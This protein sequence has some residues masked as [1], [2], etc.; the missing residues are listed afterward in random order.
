M[1]ANSSYAVPNLQVTPQLLLRPVVQADYPFLQA[2][3]REVRRDELS[4]T[5]WPQAAKDAFCDSQFSLQDQHYR[6]HYPDAQFYVVE[7]NGQTIGRI[8]FS[9]EEGLLALMEI[10]LLESTRGQ[11]L[12]LA[13]MKWLM[14]WADATGRP[15]RLYVEP[16]N[17][18]KRL[19]LHCGFEEK[20][21]DGAYQRM[22]R[23]EAA[24]ATV[25]NRD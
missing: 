19:Y 14:T 4:V 6:Q 13:L 21:V 18:A 16:N 12:G 10:S 23:P 20:E 11:G 22:H 24:P 3:Y 9:N 8:Y 2:L 5:G 17:P 15:M 7:R 1:P 25:V